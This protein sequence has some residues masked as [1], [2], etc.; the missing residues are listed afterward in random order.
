[1]KLSAI[2]LNYNG[3]QDTIDC[4]KSIEKNNAAEVEVEIIV[5]DNNPKE[6]S[7]D[8]LIKFK[9]IIIL[10]NKKNLG[11]SGGMNVG[12]KEALKNKADY[13]LILNNDINLDRLFLNKIIQNL[14]SKEIVAPKIYFAKGYE[15]HKKRYNIADLGKVIWFA[16]GK[17]DW[18]NIIGLH[19]GV[20][21]V[22]RGQYSRSAEVDY[23][24]GACM[25]I[26]KQVFKKIGY[27]DEKYF[28]YLEDMDFCFRAKRE[29][30]NVIYKPMAVAWHKNAAS[31]GGSGSKLQDYYISRNRLLFAFKYSKI[32]TKLAVLK[33]I[34]SDIKK[35]IKRQALFDFLLFN[36]GKGSFTK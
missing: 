7:T 1:M 11:F 3:V 4:L 34:V 24:T 19:I 30:F 9:N 17:I 26:P 21:E 20:D 36:F 10:R 6:E 27:F 16:G 2:I 31:A 12:I 33:Q 35:P 18:D 23:A 22:D 13:V 25:L 5:V 32:K 28:L 29:G 14:S 8:K 15:F